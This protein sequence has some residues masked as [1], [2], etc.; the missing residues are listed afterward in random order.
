M[1]LLDTTA[2]LVLDAQ[3]RNQ[4]GPPIPKTNVDRG[5]QRTNNWLSDSHGQKVQRVYGK[6]KDYVRN[7]PL[8]L[9]AAT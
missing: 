4:R 6:K 3:L 9:L 7:S 1:I 5:E 8:L 2:I